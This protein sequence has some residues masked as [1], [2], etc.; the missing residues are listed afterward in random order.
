MKSRIRAAEYFVVVRDDDQTIV[1]STMT[2][3]GAMAVRD[4][5]VRESGDGHSCLPASQELAE[6]FTSWRWR[7]EI[8]ER[9][10]IPTP[11]AVVAR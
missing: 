8:V 10:G 6:E 4:K 7:T 9:D 11:V 3:A 1:A 2:L 5:T